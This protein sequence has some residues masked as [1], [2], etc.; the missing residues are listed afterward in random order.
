M[1]ETSN[2]RITFHPA[3]R[4]CIEEGGFVA[5]GAARALFLRNNMQDYFQIGDHG[6]KMTETDWGGGFKIKFP[7]RVKPAGDIDVFFPDEGKYKAALQRI[8]LAEYESSYSSN[9]SSTFHVPM[10][11]SQGLRETVALQLIH[12]VFGSPVD[13]ISNFDLVN[14]SVAITEKG[15]VYDS[16]VPSLESRHVLK[17]RRSDSTTLIKRIS[18]YILFRDIERVDDD[19][20]DMITDWLLRYISNDFS[21]PLAN[22]SSKLNA[23]QLECVISAGVMD[24]NHLV[25]LVNRPEFDVPIVVSDADGGYRIVGKTNRI[26]DLIGKIAEPI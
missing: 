15:F 14:C 11:T 22:N 13:M 23:K 2:H 4:I 8:K 16:L 26:H 7:A 3:V 9:M 12:C 17:L 20:R 25:Y 5:G 1:I 21:G 24:R 10:M 19:T 6:P 18:K